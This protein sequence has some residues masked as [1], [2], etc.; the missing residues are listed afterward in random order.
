MIRKIK[1]YHYRNVHYYAQ[2][3]TCDWVCG[4]RTEKAQSR[5]DVRNEI[6]KHVRKTG[7]SVHLESGNSTTYLEILE[8]KK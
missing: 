1:V 2:C 4:I 8:K 6:R 3:N 7:H 5:S